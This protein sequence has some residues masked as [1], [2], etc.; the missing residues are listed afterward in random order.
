MSLVIAKCTELKI[1]EDH[2]TMYEGAKWRK[3]TVKEIIEFME[4]LYIRDCSSWVH[5]VP[6][7]M[8]F[9]KKPNPV[10]YL[11][12]LSTIKMTWEQVPSFPG[13]DSPYFC[14]GLHLAYHRYL[15]DFFP[16]LTHTS[17]PHAIA[18]FNGC[19]LPSFTYEDLSLFTLP[20]FTITHDTFVYVY[21]NVHPLYGPEFCRLVPPLRV[22]NESL[23]RH[24]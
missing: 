13:I 1:A 2:D 3:Y 9:F 24:F 12:P 6:S 16:K 19:N 18:N 21:Y 20:A 4:G 8:L 22:W 23:E 7:S 10:T 17:S 14:L 11:V 15:S 5:T